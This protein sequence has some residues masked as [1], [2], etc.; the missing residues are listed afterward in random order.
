[1]EDGEGRMWPYVQLPREE[2]LLYGRA[3]RGFL[4][5]FVPHH[6]LGQTAVL[7]GPGDRQEPLEKQ[8]EG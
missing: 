8:V 3:Q 4:Q 7:L 1:M 6:L 2:Y 5:R